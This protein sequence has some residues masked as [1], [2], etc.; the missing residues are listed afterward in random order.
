MQWASHV[1]CRIRAGP[2]SIPMIRTS[3]LYLNA[4]HARLVNLETLYS[5][6]PD[7]SERVYRL[8]KAAR[9]GREASEQFRLSTGSAAAGSR[10][11]KAAWL[12]LH[13][14]PIRVSATQNYTVWRMTDETDARA[15]QEEAFENLQY[16]IN[17]LDH[18]P[19]G[20]FSSTHEGDIA[21][22]NATLAD[23]LGLDLSQTTDGQLK[24][25]D[26]VTD[27]GAKLLAGIEP[28]PGRPVTEIFNLDLS[29]SNGETIPAR[30]VHRCEY[31][32]RWQAAALTYAGARPA[33]RILRW[34]RKQAM[35]KCRLRGCSIR[36][37]LV[38]YSST[39]TALSTS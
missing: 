23:W 7:V 5:G 29:T 39:R 32:S 31:D 26:I 4:G 30:V 15:S 9:E 38:L 12:R 6:Y 16:I 24:L 25:A 8:A 27:K 3:G 35:H 21:Y 20:F 1:S 22:V 11:N 2:L 18:A 10:E 37:R 13:V 34:R 33:G 36:C 14:K 28:D 19:A 17:Y